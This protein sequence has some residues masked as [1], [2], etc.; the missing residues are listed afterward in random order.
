VMPAA[1]AAA[2]LTLVLQ[3]FYFLPRRALRVQLGGLRD[4]IRAA[5]PVSIHL[6]DSI[7]KNPQTCSSHF[8]LDAIVV[9][10]LCCPSCHCLYPY[11]P[12]DTLNATITPL[13]PSSPNTSQCTYQDTKS[14]SPCSTPL[15]KERR[16]SGDKTISVPIRKYYHQDFKSWMGRLLA[17]HDIETHIRKPQ[18]QRPPTGI[19]DDIWVSV[20]ALN[21]QQV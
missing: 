12:N 3:N 1:K 4:I 15:W 11:E 20:V 14:H 8:H 16:V 13:G 2:V 18:S 9:Q 10:Y 21:L 6:L 19:I 17:R 5:N 7:P